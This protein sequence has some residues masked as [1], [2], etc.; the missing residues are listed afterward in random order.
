MFFVASD[1]SGAFAWRPTNAALLALSSLLLSGC[2]ELIVG[3][4]TAYEPPASDTGVAGDPPDDPAPNTPDAPGSADLVTDVFE[5]PRLQG[6]D[7]LFYTDNSDEMENSIE[8]FQDRVVPFIAKIASQVPDWQLITVGGDGDCSTEGLITAGSSNWESTFVD[9]LMDNPEFDDNP[10]WGLDYAVE[11]LQ[12]TASG[13]CNTGFLRDDAKLHV[14]FFSN[15]GDGSP[16]SGSDYWQ[17]YVEDI[18]SFK[19]TPT[20][21]TISAITGPVPGGCADA[22]PGFG[23]DSAVAA[24]GGVFSDICS[25][26]WDDFDAMGQA[27]VAQNVLTLE[28]IPADD[29]LVVTING[30][31]RESG[32]SYNAAYNQV[33]F[34]TG[35]PVGG[36]VVE[37]SYLPVD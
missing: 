25:S 19:A 29:D 18:V 6:V 8:D 10:S 17:G 34:E 15:A 12:R 23:Y 16:G 9:G 5:L 14:V 11:A 2:S 26:W 31:L 30:T 32:W 20:M 24:T 3:H 28:E 36:D 4:L 35:G 13:Q 33:V 7:I 37:I 1:R 27:S 21:A 22:S